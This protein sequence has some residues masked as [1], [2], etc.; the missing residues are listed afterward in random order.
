VIA[1]AGRVGDQMAA[2]RPRSQ[3]G[4]SGFKAANY[5]RQRKAWPSASAPRAPWSRAELWVS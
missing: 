5:A 3:A 4:V 1:G 2:A